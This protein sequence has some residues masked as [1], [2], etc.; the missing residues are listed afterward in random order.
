[1]TAGHAEIYDLRGLKCPLPVLRCR[2]KLSRM[3]AGDELSVE[4][5]DPLAIID[6]P[7][8]CREDGHSLLEATPTETGHRFHIRKT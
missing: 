5:S 6:I 8:M 4:T 2:K 7:H 3:R 1:M